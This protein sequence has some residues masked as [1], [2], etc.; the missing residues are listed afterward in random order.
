MK[1]KLTRVLSVLFILCL[2]VSCRDKSKPA[3]GMVPENA[4]INILTDTY[5]AD[6]LMNVSKVRDMYRYRDSTTNYIEIT[7]HYG[8]TNT[9]VD[10]TLKYYFINK[11]KKL[12]KIYDVV[13]GKLLEMQTKVENEVNMTTPPADK[14][15]LWNG[16]V[17]YS[18]PENFITDSIAFS[19]PVKTKGI[20]TFKASYR[21]FPDDESRNP[22]VVIFFSS[23]NG[24]SAETIDHWDKCYLRKD[25]QTH[26]IELKKELT[27]TGNVFIKGLLLN[28][29]NKGVDWKKH[30][31]ISDISITVIPAGK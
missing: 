23:F 15:N 14:V 16:Q 30:A 8:Y 5:I 31:R 25:G 21:V 4:L 12:E 27:K 6:G 1:N 3:N 26:I 13:T 10:S 28:H 20:Y 19:I 22:E 29:I 2:T 11:P 9:Q 7:K 24:K 18:F 17:S